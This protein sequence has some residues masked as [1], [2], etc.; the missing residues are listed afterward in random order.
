MNDPQKHK[1]SAGAKF[2]SF[3]GIDG[4]GKSTLMDRLADWLT[5]ARVPYVRVREP[6]GTAIGEKIRQIL[7]D[8]ASSDMTGR[9]EVLLYSASRAQLTWQVIVPALER[10]EW[11]LADRFVDATFA[12]Q[13][14]GRGFDPER[15]ETIQRWATGGLWPDK[16]IL[17]DCEVALALSRLGGR[18][19][20]NRDRIEL[21]EEAFHRKVRNGYLAL[22]RRE[23]GRFVLLDASK[24]LEEV[25]EDFR[26]RFW[27]AEIGP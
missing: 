21:E 18:E 26:K 10:G 8:P 5:D 1:G 12:Y 22:A 13:G 27:L 25:V 19:G 9:A 16:T 14:F 24:P 15:L 4:C 2:V 17:L 23:P 11:V 3:E 6:G 20:A 7:L